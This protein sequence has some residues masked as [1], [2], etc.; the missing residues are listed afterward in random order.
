LKRKVFLDRHPR[1]GDLVE[2]TSNPFNIGDQK[3]GYEYIITSLG[4]GYIC[5]R[6]DRMP[7]ARNEILISD[8]NYKII[9]YQD[10]PKPKETHVKKY[11]F[12]GIPFG[13]RTTYIYD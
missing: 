8:G 3:I 4:H 10:V 11:K 1:I 12:L 13:T 7:A 9:E 2:A 5:V 6:G